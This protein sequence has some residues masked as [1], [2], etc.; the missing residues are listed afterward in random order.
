MGS[1]HQVL[2]SPTTPPS[3]KSQPKETQERSKE[4]QGWQPWQLLTTN[5]GYGS[6][7]KRL[8][9]CRKAKTRLRPTSS[10][11]NPLSP[12]S[13]IRDVS[14]LRDRPTSQERRTQMGRKSG[15]AMPTE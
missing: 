12:T 6:S 5:A 14:L 1:P 11:N 7:S 2:L 15:R 4:V 8:C 13:R 3:P 10:N 9:L